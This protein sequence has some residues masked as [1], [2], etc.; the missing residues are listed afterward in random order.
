MQIDVHAIHFSADSKLVDFIKLKLEKL[1]TY[2]KNIT[3]SEVFLRLENE[4]SL[5]NKIVEIKL[6]IPGDDLF[7]K[8]QCKSFEEA[9]DEAVDALRRQILKRKEKFK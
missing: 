9:T 3:N 5:V 6:N 4:S 7:S 1:K 8:K 2:H